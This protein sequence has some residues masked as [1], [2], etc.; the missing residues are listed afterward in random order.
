MKRWI[1]LSALLLCAP[2]CT[3]G[4]GYL[5]LV[6][7]GSEDL[8]PGGWSE[9]PYGWVVTHAANGRVAVLSVN[10][11]TNV[12][13]DYFVALGATEAHN[14]KVDTRALATDSALYDSLM[15]YDAFFFKGGDQSRYYATW[16]DSQVTRAM[17]DKFAAGGVLAGTSA[18][19]H[20]QSGV[21]FTAENGSVYPEQGLED[22]SNDRFTL[23]HDFTQNLPGLVADS[24]FIERGRSL[25]LLS[26]LAHY[27]L[28]EGEALV[29][30]GVDDQSAV[31]IDAEGLATV[32][33][34]AGAELIWA[35]LDSL[36]AVGTQF[37]A[38]G[39]HSQR[40]LSGDQRQLQADTLVTFLGEAPTAASET[41][42]THADRV[43]LMGSADADVYEAIVAEVM[44]DGAPTHLV[45]VHPENQLPPTAF[46]L[47]E[48]ASVTLL[49]TSAENNTL[50]A[51]P[52]RNAL[53]EA[54]VLVW[55][56]NTME[57]LNDFMQGGPTGELLQAHYARSGVTNVM[58]GEDSRLAGAWAVTNHRRQA[59]AA[60]RGD[61]AFTPGL[62]LLATTVVMPNTIDLST[63][64]YYENT[65]S[66]VPW[67]LT[68]YGLRYGL[69][70]N[71]NSYVRYQAEGDHTQLT[72]R[73][74]FATVLLEN[75][76]T[77]GRTAEVRNVVAYDAMEYSVLPEGHT[78]TVGYPVTRPELPYTYELEAPLS[79]LATYEAEAM[80]LTWTDPNT[81]AQA[82]AFAVERALG[83]DGEFA[84]LATVT[85]LAYQETL[86]EVGEYRYRIRAINDDTA[87]AWSEEARVSV[88]TA[89]V[90]QNPGYRLYPNPGS[91]PVLTLRGLEAPT[92][93]WWTDALGRHWPAE[94]ITPG[95]EGWH[96]AAPT[97]PGLYQLCF[98]TP[99]HGLTCLPVG[100]TR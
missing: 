68:Q 43:Y 17:A 37:A 29:G 23:R 27:G 11:E 82:T 16:K 18:G 94:R 77:V 21:V 100:R 97:Q 86:T 45:L 56:G 22:L 42:E 20:I 71:A 73:G 44:P 10:D 75:T 54:N 88:V 40:L 39:W 4:Q 13:P 8:D 3:L 38:R 48:G 41:Q 99:T 57:E 64:D 32:Y 79:P 84:P 98:T 28:N 35:N 93:L 80:Q 9:A 55:M 58:V 85:E 60:Y 12:L 7:G 25:R 95:P 96:V 24:H 70:L 78:F 31:G 66:A 61:L 5:L 72:A 67:A 46:R 6:G 89:L 47:V 36:E 53:R 51:A 14:I 91:G 65:V 33:G 34:T 59:N 74:R 83:N 62:G 92:A 1:I 19:L 81:L 49:A 90:S 52:L 69:Y 26:F 50:A 30:L 87:S 2:F 76:S 63:S 15:A